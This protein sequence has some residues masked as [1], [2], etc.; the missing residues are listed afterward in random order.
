MPER[1][2]ASAINVP[3]IGFHVS[4]EGG[5]PRAVDRTLERGCTALQMFCGNPRGWRL[6]HR[7]HAEIAEFR[8]ERDRAGL[9]MVAVH[10][11]Y[12]INL[13]AAS[14]ET[15]RRSIVRLA[16]ELRVAA[17]IG[18]DYY[19]L[20]P[21][22]HKGKP[23]EWGVR[24]VVERLGRALDDAGDAPSV[25]LENTASPHGPGSDFGRLGEVL[26]EL[27]ADR[28]KHM[29]GIALD[30]CHACGAR[31][32]LRQISQVERLA[33]DIEASVGLDNLRLLH[34]NDSRDEPGSR[35]DRHEH[36]GRGKIGKV[37]LRNILN[38]PAFAARPLILETP[39]ESV[40]VDR[41]NLRAVL[42]LLR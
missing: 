34:I 19:I 25:L 8:Q 33:H 3:P 40:T 12:L 15:A 22:S 7:S 17:Q 5:L 26:R 42:S 18:A 29:L 10:S 36:I 37:G 6:Q 13:C 23:P 28:P 31:H 14:R 35:R 41:R 2:P 27:R 21:G 4:I 20:H 1:H 11:C 16:A 24:K 9:E 32:D 38:H 39:W 30:T